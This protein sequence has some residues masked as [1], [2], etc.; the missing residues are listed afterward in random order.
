MKELESLRPQCVVGT[1]LSPFTWK[2]RIALAEAGV[3]CPLAVHRPNLPDTQVPDFNPL[4][5]VPVLVMDDGC[6]LFDSRVILDFLKALKPST[7]L[8][9]DDGPARVM[10]RRW[11]ALADGICD[12]GVLLINELD[13]RAPAERSPWWIERQQGKMERAIDAMAEGIG[14]RRYGVG[15][16]LT[17]ADIACV[18]AL[19]FVDTRFAQIAWRGRHPGLAA[20]ADRHAQRAAFHAILPARDTA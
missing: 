8:L 16:G 1:P 10:V 14:Q 15:D 17:L 2:V 19:V 4:G 7:P 6:T 5:K 20:Y 13:R 9:P 18:A 12:S 3:D 11:E